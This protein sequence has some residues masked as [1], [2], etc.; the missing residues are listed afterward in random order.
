VGTAT[1]LEG[2]CSFVNTQNF[3]ECGDVCARKGR[4]DPGTAQDRFPCPHPCAPSRGRRAHTHQKFC[5]TPFGGVAHPCAPS[6]RDVPGTPQQVRV[7]PGSCGGVPGSRLPFARAKVAPTPARRKTASLPASLCAEPGTCAAHTHPQ[8]FCTTPYPCS[9]G[10]GVCASVRDV[11]GVAPAG[12]CSTGCVRGRAGIAAAVFARKGRPDPGTAQDRFPCPHLCAP[13]RGRRAHTH[14][15]FCTTPFLGVW[16]RVCATF[17]ARP[18]R[19]VFDRVRAGAC[20]DRGCRLR[21]QRS[22][23]PRHGARPLRPTRI[24]LCAEPGTSRTHTPAYGMVCWW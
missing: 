14:Q 1:N 2:F 3:G 9:T 11:P 6:V 20:R 7:R 22:P 8:K 15:K 5:T 13:S 10:L 12:S 24:L 23:R 16:R 19:F 21:A 18:S 17:P 4:P